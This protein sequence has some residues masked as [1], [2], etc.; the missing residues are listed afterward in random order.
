MLPLT[1]EW[2]AKAE[3]DFATATHELRARRLPNYDAAPTG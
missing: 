1:A 2:V 3:A